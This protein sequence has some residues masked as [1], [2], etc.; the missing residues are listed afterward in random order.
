MKKSY[1]LGLET[2]FVL[3]LPSEVH[4]A[5]IAVLYVIG[6][7]ILLFEHCYARARHLIVELLAY[8]SSLSS[9]VSDPNSLAV[10]IQR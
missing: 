5:K 2:S 9:P 8:S 4:L 1:G 7:L 3:T 10:G 6:Y